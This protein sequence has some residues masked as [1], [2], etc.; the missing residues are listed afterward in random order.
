MNI[1]KVS[2]QNPNF[3]G[4]YSIINSSKKTL[5]RS[6]FSS[7]RGAVKAPSHSIREL[8]RYS[9]SNKACGPRKTMFASV[10]GAMFCI[11]EDLN[12]DN[13]RGKWVE[14]PSYQNDSENFTKNVE[15]LKE[16]S[17]GNWQTK[18]YNADVNLRRGDFHVYMVDGEPKVGIR[19]LDEYIYD[20]VGVNGKVPVKYFDEIKHHIKDY[21]LTG[22][23]L[24]EFINCKEQ[25]SEAEKIKAEISAFVEKNDIP[26]IL[27]RLGKPYELLPNGNII[28]LSDFGSAGHYYDWEDIGVDVNK[29]FEKV[30]KVCGDV[31]I[32]NSK[33]KTLGQLSRIEGDL[34]LV[35]STLRSLGGLKEVGGSLH[36][37]NSKLEDLGLLERVGRIARFSGS[38]VSS[39]GNVHFVGKDLI[40]LDSKICDLGKLERVNGALYCS[41]GT[42]DDEDLQKQKIYVKEGVVQIVSNRE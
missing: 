35:G 7:R 27:N 11:K 17:H 6:V 28:L 40:L 22:L 32:S 31:R 4:S 25:K 37:Q 8:T 38:N 2:A 30:V 14:I 3:Y 42:Y 24:R 20:I 10:V 26:S 21:S 39:L 23:A 41:V 33:L 29:I 15:L 5:L 12:A 36:L 16:L 19:F 13:T 34:Y 9:A 18:S 1:P